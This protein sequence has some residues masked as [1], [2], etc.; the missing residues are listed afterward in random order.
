MVQECKRG[1]IGQ[2]PW[3]SG[4]SKKRFLSSNELY[5]GTD[6]RGTNICMHQLAIDAKLEVT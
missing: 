5:L 1:Y 3:V 4:L 2:V 6:G